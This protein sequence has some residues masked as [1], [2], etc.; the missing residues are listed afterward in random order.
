MP[1]I[2]A[3]TD[4]APV[5]VTPLPRVNRLLL[6]GDPAALG[7]VLDLSLPTKPCTAQPGERTVL[8]LGPD[9]WLLLA[10]EHHPL[11]PWESDS[12]AA[13]DVTHRQVAL[14]IE[15][16]RAADVLAA[17]CPL[18]LATLPVDFCTRTVFGKAEIILLRQ[19]ETSFH[20][21]TSR[22]FAPYVQE[23][24]AESIRGLA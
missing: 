14:L 15:G 6:R 20:I 23:L 13:F 22:S 4:H 2:M 24:L 11:A 16:V 5:R 19:K 10:S 7:A 18:D 8:W 9:E 21:E 12:G 1:D 17:A 3:Q